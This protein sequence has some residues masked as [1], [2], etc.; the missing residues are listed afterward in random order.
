ML[1][2]LSVKLQDL[3]VIIPLG[4]LVGTLSMESLCIQLNK[5]NILIKFVETTTAKCQNFR[6]FAVVVSTNSRADTHALLKIS[7]CINKL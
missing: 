3:L 2:L 4:L 1:K 6:N 7:I 5:K